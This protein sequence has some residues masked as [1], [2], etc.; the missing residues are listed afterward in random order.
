MKKSLRTNQ[1]ITTMKISIFI[2]L[3]F[4]WSSVYSQTRSIT[5]TVS[6]SET[7][8]T[9]PGA[10]ILIK[11]TTNGTTTDINGN[12]TLAVSGPSA[13]LLVSFI[14]YEDKEINTEN[15][16]VINIQMITQKTMLDQVVV[17]GYGTQK[18][19]DVTG[20]TATIKGSELTKQPVLTATQAL[21]GKVAGVQIIGSSQP[22]SSP[23]VRIRGTGTM[24][25]GANPL[26]I[27]DGVITSDINNINS[28]DIVNINILKD[29]S[30]TAIYG[31]RAANGVVIITTKQGNTGK[32]K[33][34]YNGN[35]GFRS[36]VNL[37]EMANADEY[38][39][40]VNSTAL[41]MIT[42]DMMGEST[43]WFSEILRTGMQQ[44]HSISLQGGTDKAKYFLSL[45]Y[46]EEQ[47]I[48][49]NNDF[50]R[51]TARANNEFT[52]S[53]KVKIGTTASFSNGNKQDVNLGAAYNDAYRAGPIIASKVDGRYGNTSAFQNVGNPILDIENNDNQTIE[54]RLQAS[55]YIEYK[56]ID[57]L[58]LRSTIGGDL[59]SRNSRV[60]GFAF[61]N[62]TKTF[63]ID[64]GNQYRKLS[65][66]SINKA[67]EFRWV[68]DN[69]ATY[70]KKIDKHNITALAGMTAEKYSYERLYGQRSDV[71]ASRN[72]WYLD[73]GDPNTSHNGG[74]G[75]KWSRNSYLG[76]I[77][78]SYNDRYLFTGTIRAD[79]TSRF[80]EENRWGYFPSLG[81]GW[82]ISKESFM[83]DQMVF[84]TLKLRASWGRV[85][86]D[87]IPTD[88]Y[89]LT[90]STNAAYPFSN[91]GIATIG[92]AITDIKD[93][94]L[95]WEVTEET[96][97]GIEFTSLSGS[98][99]G[100]FGFYNKNTNDALINV[101]IPGVLGDQDSYVVTNAASFRNTGLEF[102]LNWRKE[103]TSKLYYNIGGNFTFNQNEVT[104]LNGGQPFLDGNIGAAQGAV[105]RTDNG[106]PIGSFY[107]LQVLGIFQNDEE[108]QNYKNADGTLIQPTARPGDFKYKKNTTTGEIDPINDRVYVGSYQPKFYFGLNSGITYGSFDLSLDIYG[109]VGNQVYNA[110]KAFRQEILDNVEKDQAYNRWTT[111]NQSQTEPRAN[112]G[113]QLASTYFVESGTYFRI[114]NMTFGYSIPE[115]ILKRIN[116]SNLRVFVTSQN[117]Y[118]WQKYSGFTAE[119]P[120]G[121]TNSG[122]EMNAYP[123]SRTIAL[124]V[125]VDF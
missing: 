97:L 114:N 75:D 44:N 107:V 25:A 79:G 2:I 10:T 99:S 111:S 3:L 78:Y 15:Q 60:Y 49:I 59:G 35:V 39:N 83:A 109:N 13:I 125:N 81:V 103:V 74:N 87:N 73:V 56:P 30:S 108:I 104:G 5:G 101:R 45:G 119:L 6:D 58:S 105:T 61:Q 86:N 52:V 115:A 123:N 93:P 18:K 68:W 77:N 76:R 117:L 17:V 19:S 8:E 31:M 120:G 64:G 121:P 84:E 118:T 47:G 116:I 46:L 40:Y 55:G 70:S 69:T 7:K 37:V 89:Q 53:D 36:A 85:G 95:R 100:E 20:A 23:I 65:D 22:G 110:K 41:N 38:S 33:V 50:K 122:I 88:S 82:L 54:N 29:A 21:Q 57:W 63:L 42:P 66:L 27:V 62:D 24:L 113:R 28:N 43:D 124:G 80:P 11:G 90:V 94:N 9:L 112:S 51:F 16:S 14:G 32:L 92:S 26:F 102:A 67:N 34:S 106:Q 98:L 1:F 12:F 72:L 71:P 4:S 91:A 96:D 48:V